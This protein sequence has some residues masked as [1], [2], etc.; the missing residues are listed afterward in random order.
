MFVKISLASACSVVYYDLFCAVWPVQCVS[1]SL[2]LSLPAV[3]FGVKTFKRGGKDVKLCL[4][5]IAGQD[6]FRSLMPQYARRSAA[7][8]VMCDVTRKQTL[9]EG[10]RLWKKSADENVFL[11]NGQPIPSVLLVNKYDLPRAQRQLSSEEIIEF[12]KD[13]GFV[14]HF[15]TSVRDGTN[16]SEALEFVVDVIKSYEE[17]G[18]VIA[19][20]YDSDG[21]YLTSNYTANKRQGSACCGGG[22]ECR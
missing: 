19:Q 11:P 15:E 1:D 5:D 10:A 20:N 2:S 16:I 8:I 7:C 18:Q 4:W 12:A 13:N 17:D 6:P 3:E 14:R 21:M 22:T 9:L